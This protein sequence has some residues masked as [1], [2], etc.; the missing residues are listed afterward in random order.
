MTLKRVNRYLSALLLLL[1]V[2]V[3]FATDVVSFTC[4]CEHHHHTHSTHLSHYA[5]EHSGECC[6][7]AIADDGCCGHDHTTEVDLYTLQRTDDGQYNRLSLQ[8][9]AVTGSYLY[10]DFS[11]ES[12]RYTYSE[13]IL[14]RKI[15]LL[16]RG[17]SL[18]APPQLV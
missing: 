5:S 1:Y 12:S 6:G 16:K 14:P 4:S 9:S 7:V 11:P 13:Y 3:A 2:V 10:C 17:L 18:R 15:L 8:L